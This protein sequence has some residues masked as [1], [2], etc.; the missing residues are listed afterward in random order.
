MDTAVSTITEDGPIYRGVNATALADP[1]PSNRPRR[2]CGTRKHPIRLRKEICLTSRPRCRRSSPPPI[3]RADRSRDRGAVARHRSRSHRLQQHAEGRAVT[4]ARILRLVAAVMLQTPP[5]PAPIHEQIVQAWALNHGHATR[6][7]PPRARAARR[8][9]IERVDLH[10]ALRG[11]DGHLA[12]RCGDRRAGRAQRSASR[13]RGPQAS[14]LLDTLLAGDIAAIVRER[15]ALGERFPG[16]GHMVYRDGD[17]RAVSLFDALVRAGIDRR[18]AVEIPDRI[19]EATGAI[20]QLR[21]RAGRHAPRARHAGRQ[22]NDDLRHGAHGR[23]DCTCQ[24]AARKPKTDP[25]AC[26]LCGA[27]TRARDAEMTAPWASRN[28]GTVLIS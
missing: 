2:C 11:V 3:A 8:S 6:S 22:R 18:F 5:K 25:S 20:S 23:M 26:P 24:R 28:I 21:L 10:R 15:V 27:C 7:D 16:F 17:P 14:R 13:R 19:R 12:I 4:G 1:R 9:R